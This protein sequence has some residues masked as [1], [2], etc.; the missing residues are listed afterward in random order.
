MSTSIVVSL[1]SVCAGGSHLALGIAVDG[2][3]ARHFT[4]DADDVRS[5]IAADDLQDAIRVILR[6]HFKGKTRAQ[7]RTELQ[8][9]F[10]VIV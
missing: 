5:P 3:A 1:D 6:A 7:A 8:S 9:G 2:A 10:T 4:F